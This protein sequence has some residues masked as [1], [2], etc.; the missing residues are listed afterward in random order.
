M[1]PNVSDLFGLLSRQLTTALES[2]RMLIFLSLAH[3]GDVHALFFSLPLPLACL[4]LV[5]CSGHFSA[6]ELQLPMPYTL[7]SLLLASP[8]RFLTR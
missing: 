2:L 6:T 3:H 4:V 8:Q 1:R 7:A 5:I